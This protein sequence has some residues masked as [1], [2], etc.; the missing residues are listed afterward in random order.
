[1]ARS[2]L[3]SRRLRNSGAGI[4][5]KLAFEFLILTAARSGEVRLATWDEIDTEA[6]TWT[7]PAARMKAGLEHRVPLCD[8]AMA[9]LDEARAIA[10]GSRLIFPGTRAGKPLS[11][12]TLSKL[13]RDLGLDGVPHGFR[14]SFRDWAAE[15]TNASG[16]VMEAALAHTVRNTVEGRLQPYRPLRAPPHAHGSMGLLPRRHCGRCRTDGAS[17]Q[18]TMTS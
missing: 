17:W 4:A 8:R 9:I 13:M 10:D 2:Q 3:P 16:E 6:A 12:M 7:V 18:M 15:C 1:M 11:D 14:S 5:V